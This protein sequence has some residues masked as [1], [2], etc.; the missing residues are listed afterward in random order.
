MF[1][2]LLSDPVVLLIV[3]VTFVGAIVKGATN[4]GLNLLAVPALAPIVG[5]P[6]AVLTIF[7]AKAVSDVVMLLESRT[8]E[9][10][11]PAR[12]VMGFLVA[13]FLGVVLGTFLL[14]YLDRNLLFL[15]LGSLLLLY[16]ALET[17]RRALVIPPA[18]E[19]YW[20]PV[21]GGLS[22]V[23]QGLTGAAGPTTA[24]YMLSLD[25]TPR[26][27]VFLTSVI[28][29]AINTGQIAGILYLDLY[30]EQRLI[31][32]VVAFAPVM[33]GTWIGIRLRGRLSSRGFRNAILILLLLMALNM[34]R[35]GMGF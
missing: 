13:G 33:L 23:S 26:E 3:A 25:L 12:R 6:T 18:Q 32:A 14:A 28:F 9:G 34:L 22:G 20:G 16:L 11:R 1:T 24:I 21:A 5:V 7:I 27:F 31:Y 4:M 2:D 8:S 30:T 35:L 29:I 15:I 19:K 10:L 17:R